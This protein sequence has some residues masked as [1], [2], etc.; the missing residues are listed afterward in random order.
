MG[1]LPL[2]QLH[3]LDATSSNAPVPPALQVKRSIWSPP[4]DTG[5]WGL[6]DRLRQRL[7][8]ELHGPV[9]ERLEA[10]LAYFDAVTAVSGK[11]YP[12]PKVGGR[13]VGCPPAFASRELHLF[14]PV[15]AAAC[16]RAC[17]LCFPAWLLALL[18]PTPLPP[19]SFSTPLQD[20]RKTAAV[21]FLAEVGPPPRGDLYIPTNPHCRVLGVIPESAAPMQVRSST[22]AEVLCGVSQQSTWLLLAIVWAYY[23]PCV[24]LAH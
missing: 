19:P 3:N 8:G 12:V 20:E 6:A 7:L 13:T 4:A 2:L 22:A 24:R 21:R 14:G 23:R 18:S 9:M 11:L 17:R 1:L 5:L 16:L 15:L 10:E